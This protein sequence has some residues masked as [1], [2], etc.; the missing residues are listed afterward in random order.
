M[1]EVKFYPL[2]ESNKHIE[3]VDHLTRILNDK[4]YLFFRNLLDVEKVSKL[5][6][7]ILKILSKNG[8]VEKQTSEPIWT[9]KEYTK[10]QYEWMFKD[11]TK[12]VA[13]KS[14][15]D[16]AK[17]KEIVNVFERLLGGPIFVWTK[18]PV[19]VQLPTIEDY[20][21]LAHQDYYYGKGS[22]FFITWVPLMN[23][24][25]TVGGLS[26]SPGSHKTV[27]FNADEYETSKESMF[28][29]LQEDKHD[30][31]WHRADYRPGDVVIFT[32]HTVHKGLHNTSKF[33]RISTEF[34][35]QLKGTNAQWDAYTK[36][37]Y[38]VKKK[39]KIYEITDTLGADKDLQEKVLWRIYDDSTTSLQSINLDKIKD[40]MK[41]ISKNHNTN[42]ST[43]KLKEKGI[44]LE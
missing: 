3:D 17:S 18:K 13:L 2:E 14:L 15:R 16:L 37:D 29:E 36:D 35:Y 7:D 26:L 1:N 31:K 39:K 38:F 25:E 44:K 11:Y 34:R 21:V 12:I 28:P 40:V 20:R 9:G 24:D 30:L 32:D 42:V 4:G 23:I 27:T 43:K 19:R 22:P 41:E 5:Q 10:D 33:I 6:L 8:F